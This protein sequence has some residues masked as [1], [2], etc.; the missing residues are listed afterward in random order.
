MWALDDRAGDWVNT[1]SDAHTDY[2]W[3][4][5]AYAV[6]VSRRG[7]IPVIVSP[8][9]KMN[10]TTGEVNIT[11]MG[12]YPQAAKEAAELAGCAFI[13]LNAMSVDVVKGL[14]ATNAPAAYTDGLHTST[15]G[16]YLLSRCIV[17]GIR[18]A[19]LD[20][21]KYITPDAG[22]FNPAAPQ[23]LPADFKLP[24]DPRVPVPAPPGYPP[25]R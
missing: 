23:P 3:L 12:D 5:A 25:R 6:E 20:L 7:G 4:L 24:L 8:M 22:S 14:G 19:N 18:Q 17:E 10:R 16:G 15:Y 1:H 2:K 21:A 13:D 9:T 11:G